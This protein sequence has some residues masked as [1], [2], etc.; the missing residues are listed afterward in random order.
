MNGDPRRDGDA[1]HARPCAELRGVTITSSP[2]GF[3]NHWQVPAFDTPLWHGRRTRYAVVIPVLNEGLR[4]RRLLSRMAGTGLMAL[5]DVTVIDGGS[6]DD[7][8]DL[9]FLTRLGVR[10][11]LIKTGPGRLSAQLRCAYAFALRE[12]YAGVVTIDGNDKDDPAAI[13]D[14]LAALQSGADF[15]QGSRFILGG[16]AERTPLLRHL[17]IRLLHAPVLALAS[18]FPWTDTT[19]GFRAYSRQLLEDERLSVFRD[20]F[21]GYELL[22]DLSARAPKLKFRCQELPTTRRYP[23]GE[24]TPTKIHGLNGNLELL[25]VLLSAAAGRYRP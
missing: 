5:A 6:S 3:P 25:Q 7:S 16:N 21:Q 15:V 13:P 4:I 10:G 1:P 12:G 23:H 18:G 14:F 2:A 8:L 11:L 9:A 17:A 22:A 24:A 19:Q 20:V